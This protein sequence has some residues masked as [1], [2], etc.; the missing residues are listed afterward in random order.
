[1]LTASSAS[2]PPFAG[3]CLPSN[4]TRRVGMSIRLGLRTN[5]GT[6]E[7]IIRILSRGIGGEKCSWTALEFATTNLDDH[8][9]TR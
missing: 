4:N 9:I 6:P 8:P 5:T 7:W 3:V 1:M 2:F